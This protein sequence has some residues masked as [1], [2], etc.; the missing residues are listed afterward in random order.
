MFSSSRDPRRFADRVLIPGALFFLV[1]LSG[2]GSGSS[3]T[4]NDLT[5][6]PTT[7]SVPQGGTAQFSAYLNG[8]AV[9]G[10]WKATAGTISSSGLFTAPTSSNAVQIT[11]TSGS[12]SGTITVNISAAQPLAV[13]PAAIALPAGQ[14]F[15]FTAS[16]NGTTVSANWTVSTSNGGNP[17]TIDANGNY[18]PPLFPPPGQTV[19]VTATSG[20][21]SGTSNVVIIYSNSTLNGTY[22]FAYTGD[23]GSGF[24]TVAGSFTADGNGNIGTGVE[25]A[26]DLGGV[27]SAI[28][29]SG[30]SYTV[31]ADGRTQINLTAGGS[32]VTLEAAL[33]TNL[34]A[35]VI[36][37]DTLATGSGT[38]DQQNTADFNVTGPY[39]FTVSGADFGFAP[40]ALA[41]K[42]TASNLNIPNVN[43]IVDVNDGGNV[44]DNNGSGAPGDPDTS[45]SGS[46]SFDQNNL[47]SGR[48]TI[49]LN[50]TNFATFLPSTVQA[51]VMFAF[52][53]VDHTHLHLVEIDGNA[54]TSGDTYEGLLG[55]GFGVGV[56]PSGNYAF[57]VGGTSRAG[58]Y[59]AG[60]VFSSDGNGDVSGGTFDNNSAGSKINKALNISKCPLTIDPATGRV[61]ML[62]GLSSSCGTPSNNVDEFAYYPSALTSPS[63]VMLEIDNNFITSGIAYAQQGTPVS[64][65]GSFAF[66][67]TGQG[68]FHNVAGSYQQDALGQLTL[69]GTSV[70]SGNV[71]INNYGDVIPTSPVVSSQS[72][73]AAVG[74]IGRGTMMLS[75]S[76]PSG[77]GTAVYNFAYYYA[78]S[79]TY[80]LVDLDSN[81]IADGVIADQF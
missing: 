64:P 71:N 61:D 31:G 27:N 37:Y 43:A 58:A 19:T 54:F 39:V 66:N 62:L 16:A 15:S 17:G 53:I 2:C 10:T 22:A 50:A 1:V 18:T 30:G 29:I 8:A 67:L 14:V 4:V 3:S 25:D 20:G 70:T 80:L 38:V 26:E 57:T 79:G 13:S 6:L 11:V 48:G 69:A 35:L 34:H 75:V 63:A 73:L 60:G 77:G 56:L 74:N 40:L 33:T 55:P 52:Y 5:I 45:L 76:I 78:G 44:N 51:Q 36:R 28:P 68:I 81:R 12:N 24:F 32:P 23:D 59:A 65:T 47:A 9:S 7:A 21:N 46:Y 41:G 49:T 42:F 72:T